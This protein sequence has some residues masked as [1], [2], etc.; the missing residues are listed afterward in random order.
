[1]KNHIFISYSTKDKDFV[2]KLRE[3]LKKSDIPV[4]IDTE[5]IRPGAPSWDQVIRDAIQ[6]SHAVFLIATPD[7]RL[8]PYVQD[9]LAIAKM[10]ECLVVPIWFKG[11]HF[12]DCV[13]L[14]YG[15]TQA[16]NIQE[17]GY[18]IALQKIA[19]A[20]H[21]TIKG[22]SPLP[23]EETPSTP[24]P[25]DPDVS[26]P[27]K[28]LSAFQEEDT[29]IFFG[30]ETLADALLKIVRAQIDNNQPRFLAV[31]GASGSGKSS[32][33]MAGLLPKLDKKLWKTVKMVPTK[34]PIE[35]LMLAL[36]ETYDKSMSA[37]LEDLNNP[38]GLGLQWI[39]KRM[40]KS[41]QRVLLFVDQF[42]E[43]FTLAESEIE[44]GQLLHL[45]TSATTD[46][47]GNLTVVITMRADYYDRPMNYRELGELIET[48]QKMVLPMTLA[49][50]FDAISKP[51][52]RFGV[53]FEPELVAEI[54]FALRDRRDALAGAL[55]LLQFTLNQLY[56][57]RAGSTLTRAAYNDIGG[58]QGAIGHHADEVFKPLPQEAQDA[59]PRVAAK[60]VS[61]DETN[62]TRRRALFSEFADHAPS[63]ALVEALINARLL[64]SDREA[65]HA[66]VEVAHE[67][68]LTHWGK[69]VQT[70]DANKEGLRQ[71]RRLELDAKE[72]ESQGKPSDMQWSHARL[73]P[74]YE[75]ADALG[76]ELDIL[77]EKFA[78]PE[79]ERLVGEYRTASYNRR[80]VIEERWLELGENSINPL[81][82]ALKDTSEYVRRAAA[83]VLGKLGDTSVVPRL[84]DTLRDVDGSV[85]SGA[86]EALGNLGDTSIV[87]Y[88]IDA[89]KDTSEFVRVAAAEA[90]GKL[91]DTSVV[92]HLIDAL[93]DTSEY[94][95]GAATGALGKLGD[96]S[97]VPH[98]ID[99]LKDTSEHVQG[100]VIQTLIKFGSFA[101]P[102]LIDALKDTSEFVRRAAAEALGNLGD[103]S[104]V[105][106]L[107][108][109][110]KDTSE[111]VRRAVT[112]A[113]GKL[114]DASVVPHLIDALKDTSKDVRRA[115]AEALGKLGDASVVPHLID[116]LRD[117][118]GSVR[119]GA[120][121]ALGNLG[122]TSVVPRLIDALK[123]TSEYVRGA[124]AEALGKLGDTS[125]VPHLIDA[126]KGAS[127]Y[128][129]NA[130]IK[131][132]TKFGSFAVPH[133]IDALKDTSEFVR[134][135]AAEALGNLGDTSVV[136][137]LLNTLKDG[138]RSVRVA[139]AIALAWLGDRSGIPYLVQGL[140]SDSWSIRASAAQALGYLGETNTLQFLKNKLRYETDNEVCESLAWAIAQFN[141]FSQASRF[142]RALVSSY[143]N[144][145]EKVLFATTL[146]KWG[147][148][149]ALEAVRKWREKRGNNG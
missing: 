27:Y 14:G 140:T 88:F 48:Q 115:T 106:H 103:T 107:I 31:I 15:K 89:L 85:R 73:Q 49:E 130:I 82:D 147:T 112:E 119:S 148:P 66:Y 6:N 114:G 51:A 46:L 81:I 127:E 86:I 2:V 67:A 137:P 5:G 139:A 7:A 25:L 76:I 132:L 35:S 75:L 47:D 60:L 70:V 59:L 134:G 24:P 99:A 63:Q 72:W 145:K 23:A 39:A 84:I 64:V 9:E 126:L 117:V 18:D 58:V 33:V 121:E 21:E 71:L 55:P 97:V 13:P 118:D 94:V 77:T 80:G 143:W 111:F 50:L 78:R 26:S 105:P 123:D 10:Y 146:E 136:P 113:L 32:V 125:V 101:V 34:K 69:L 138:H 128:V 141:D 30:R 109:A 91:G 95:R 149:D 142:L 36:A 54:V 38:N 100:M 40:V 4:W 68:L 129:R 79:A 19:A 87:P 53:H 44:R 122:D 131:A 93:K 104:V 110:L 42:E 90:L 96:T 124:A 83:E 29:S 52:E 133:L 17:D 108:D 3:D 116:T 102:H 28:G 41:G 135:A 92:P 120:I 62:A 1:M 8:S 16:V 22:E 65:D 56:E 11:K 43:V 12:I 20:M 144:T 98:L 45:L 61:V 74:I 57:K 37:I